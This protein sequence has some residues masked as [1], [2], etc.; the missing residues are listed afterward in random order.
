MRCSTTGD[1]GGDCDAT[2]DAGLGRSSDTTPE[3]IAG[4][5][6]RLLHERHRENQALAPARVLNLVVVVDREWKGEIANR[7]ARVGRY[8]ASRT[9]LCAVEERPPQARRAGADE[10]RGAAGRPRGDARAGR[11]RHR[12]RAPRRALE[13]IVDPVLWSELPTM[14]WSPHGHEQAVDALRR[15]HRRAAARL[16]RQAR[17]RPPALARAAE[18]LELRLRGRSGLA[19]HDAVARA[20]RGELRSPG[21]AV[22]AVGAVASS[23]CATGRARA[24]SRCCSRDGSARGSD[25][26]ASVSMTAG[27]RDL[28]RATAARSSIELEPVDQDAPGLAGVTVACGERFS[29]SLDRAP[30]GLRARETSRGPSADG[31]C[32]APRA[33]RAGSSARACGRRCCAIPP[34]GR[35][36]PRRRS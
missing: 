13:T 10:L 1:G 34:T 21:A 23:R 8:H 16:R 2:G 28:R 19:A 22:D 31:R 6:R 36:S 20:A 32:S 29:L 11:D 17:R 33:A 12:P 18:L 5:L 25:G 15:A 9:V 3:A 14:L 26:S 27:A 35:R 24:P 7:L 4:A 30:G